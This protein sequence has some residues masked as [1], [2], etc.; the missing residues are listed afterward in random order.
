M[1]KQETKT[2]KL[3]ER[4]KHQGKPCEAGESITV[5]ARLVPL[6]ERWRKIAP[7][8]G[9]KGEASSHAGDGTPAE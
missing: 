4:H 2:V 7:Q 6:L 1:P 3:L 8:G 5:S 9:G